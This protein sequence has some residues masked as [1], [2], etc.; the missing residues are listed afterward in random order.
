M[1]VVD[2]IMKIL[3]EYDWLQIAGLEITRLDKTFIVLYPK[4]MS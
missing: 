3:A 2:F 4:I 1:S